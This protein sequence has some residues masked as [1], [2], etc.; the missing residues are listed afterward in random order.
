MLSVTTKAT[1]SSTRRCSSRVRRAYLDG[2]AGCS[3]TIFS[4]TIQGLSNEFLDLAVALP[5]PPSLPPYST[6]IIL[7]TAVTRLVFTVPFSV[8]AKNRAWRAENLVV[9][10]LQQSVP[11]VHKKVLLNM[12]NDG[13]RGDRDAVI[14][15][16]SKRVKAEM[17]IRRSE[18][19]AQHRCSP[20]PTFLAPPI[21]QLPLF[22]G[23]SMALSNASQA[24]SV[25]DSES[26]MTL[27][28]LA[29]PDPTV[30]LPIVLGLVTLA[31]VESARWFLSASTL[32]REKKVAKWTAERRAKG[33]AVVEPK[34]IIQTSLRVLSI[35]RILIAAVVP[36]SIQIYWVTSATFGLIQSW[37]LDWWDARRT[38]RYLQ[39]RSVP[40]KL[41]AP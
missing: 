18:L 39:S 24:P 38:Q 19:F 32:E 15:E 26:F 34:R 2:R 6:T 28:S 1:F 7:V 22:V 4:S 37:I 33:E 36:G 30:T 3:R 9:P 35:G 41:S 21:T 5:L 16:S 8:W 10:Q 29:H 12:K 13:F 11:Q 17:K 31:N 20:I 27:T 23:L 25:F 40:P 14:A